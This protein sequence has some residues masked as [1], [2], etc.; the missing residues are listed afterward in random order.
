[1]LDRAIESAVT[2]PVDKIIDDVTATAHIEIFNQ[3]PENGVVID[4]RAEAEQLRQPLSGIES[5]AIPFHELNQKFGKLDQ[6]KAY[7]LYC[8]KGVMSQLHAQYLK[9]KG[10]D[11]VTVY[12]PE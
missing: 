10:F 1:V 7:L 4:I 9:D 5:I 6:S 8:E 3:V 2:I 11:N 12:R